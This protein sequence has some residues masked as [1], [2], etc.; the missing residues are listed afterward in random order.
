M[1][2]YLYMILSDYTTCIGKMI[3]SL[4]FNSV[5]V[6]LIDILMSKLAKLIVSLCK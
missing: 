3:I 6:K 2:K 1:T 5:K 4:N